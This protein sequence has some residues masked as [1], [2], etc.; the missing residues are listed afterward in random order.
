MAA[1]QAQAQEMYINMFRA[2]LFTQRSPLVPPIAQQ[3]LSFSSRFDALID[4]LNME[5]SNSATVVRRPAFTRFCSAQ[6]N[7]SNYPLNYYSFQKLDGTIKLVVDTPNNIYTFTTSVL[8]SIFTK[9]TTAPT[10]FQKVGD[11]LYMGN[12]VD[13]KKWNG[14]TISRWGIV[15]PVTGP[16]ISLSAGTLS[17][18]TGYVYAYAYK[19][20]S[21]GHVSTASPRSANTGA[22]TSKTFTLQGDR[23]TDSQVDK[24]EIYR[25]EDG[26]NKLNFLAEI[27]NPV[28]GTWS[29]ADT[30]A[31]SGLNND[32]HPAE[33]NVND[34]PPTGT[35]DVEFH[36]GRMW[37]AVNNLV[38]FG[39]GGDTLIGVPEE[40]F[41]PANVFSFPGKVIALASHSAGL[42]VF[43]G[44][45]IFIIYG[46][47]T[48][49]FASKKWMDNFGIKNANC[50]AQDGDLLYV[51]TSRRQLYEIGGNLEE[52]G[53]GIGDLL[54]TSFDPSTTS[55]ALHRNGSDAGLF[56]SNGSTDIY[57]YNIAFRCWSPVGRPVGGIGTLASIETSAGTWT[58]LGGR[59]AGSGYILGRDTT[60]FTDDGGT[61]TAYATIGSLV[62]ANPGNVM[63]ID[64][65]LVERMPVGTSHTL[66]VLLNEISGTFVSLPVTAPDPWQIPAASSITSTRHDLKQAP[67]PLYQGIRHLQIKISFASEAAKSEILGLALKPGQ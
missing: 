8:T 14:T 57:K 53:F 50:V 40:C 5:L 51:Y 42:L 46:S 2:G 6:F 29:F 33:S 56:I 32:I 10:R 9:N 58:L 63:T 34:P 28:A 4:G 19:N 37:I 36:M 43:T 17:P 45:A 27:A 24:V 3:G 52:V 44:D 7:S 49:T 66:G 62:L 16:S 67:Q 15:A 54:K 23:S 64:S 13:V 55:L 65:V 48:L 31:D 1:K 11:M 22:Q 59:T 21:T 61:Y 25:S 20:S 39:A 12:G 35:S 47:D 18:K 26:A 60:S 38:Y 30:T 41:P